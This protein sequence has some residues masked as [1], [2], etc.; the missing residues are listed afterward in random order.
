MDFVLRCAEHEVLQKFPNTGLEYSYRIPGHCSTREQRSVHGLSDKVRLRMILYAVDIAIL[1]NNIDELAE[2]LNIYDKTF[3]RYG[4]KILTG[5]TET[6]PF[7]V[8]E[9]IKS[10]PSLFSIGK[11]QLRTYAF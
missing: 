9:E 2:I 6:M 7:N 5:K 11:Y 1:C 4:L 8:P 10:R 3:T